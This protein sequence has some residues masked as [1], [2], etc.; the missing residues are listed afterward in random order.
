M[1]ITT[2]DPVIISRKADDTI[3]LYEELGFVRAH[4]RILE[5]DSPAS[6]DFYRDLGYDIDPSSDIAIDIM[7]DADGHKVEVAD[8]KDIPQDLVHIRMNVDDFEEAYNTL[9]AHGFKNSRGDAQL[10]AKKAKGAMM[11]SPSGFRILVIKHLT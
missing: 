2:F 8:A 1:K 5:L 3:R 10:T 6:I 9:A 4:T 7:K 11:V